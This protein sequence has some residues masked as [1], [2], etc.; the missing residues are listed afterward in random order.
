MKPQDDEPVS[1]TKKPSKPSRTEEA[2]RIV[3]KYADDLREIL[4]KFRKLS[5]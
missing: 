1:G 4:K 2:R 5:S 3:E